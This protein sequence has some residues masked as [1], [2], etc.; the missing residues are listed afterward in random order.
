MNRIPIPKFVAVKAM[1]FLSKG[2]LTSEQA[3]NLFDKA[4]SIINSSSSISDAVR[5]AGITSEQ[6]DM[7]SKYLPNLKSIGNMFGIG[8]FT[9]S[10]AMDALNEIKRNTQPPHNTTQAGDELSRYRQLYK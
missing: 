5:K 1:T 9:D 8:S 3:G 4:N 2:K 7:A 6:V 10:E